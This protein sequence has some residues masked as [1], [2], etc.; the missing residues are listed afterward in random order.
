M[1]EQ[2]EEEGAWFGTSVMWMWSES[3]CSEAKQRGPNWADKGQRV[4]KGPWASAG[5]PRQ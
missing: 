2:W 1:L 5:R 3:D 4:L